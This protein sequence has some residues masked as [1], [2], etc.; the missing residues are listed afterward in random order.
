MHLAQEILTEGDI[1]EGLPTQAGDEE[2]G[3]ASVG[4][5]KVNISPADPQSIGEA[6]AAQHESLVTGV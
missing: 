3:L 1:P 6:D 5:A 2:D 4:A